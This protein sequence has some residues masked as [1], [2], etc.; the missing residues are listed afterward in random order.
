MTDSQLEQAVAHNHAQLFYR[1]AIARGGEVRTAGDLIY[2]YDGGDF[3]SMISFPRLD[4][5]TADEQLDEMMAWYRQHPT[6]GLGC[7]SL[8]PPQPADL[9]ARLLARG[10]QD[11]W[12]PCWMAVELASVEEGI[13]AALQI[14]ADNYLSLHHLKDIPYTGEHG[15]VSPM[16]MKAHPELTQQFVALWSGQ[17]V[18]HASLFLTTGEDGVAGLYDVAVAPSVRGQGIGKALVRAACLYARARGY[19][20]AVLNATGRR[21]YEQAGF[22]H[23]GDGMTWWWFD[24]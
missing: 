17:V 19:R 6:K 9:G 10:F 7:W 24:R 21:M 22:R 20:Y 4:E 8:A 18:G 23:I 5:A 12:R 3:Q 14:V 2:T 11:G 13:P 1:N 16:L 15:A